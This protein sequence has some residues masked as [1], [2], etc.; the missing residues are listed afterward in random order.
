M[1]KQLTKIKKDTKF[2]K[3]YSAL[4]TIVLILLL[5][6]VMSNDLNHLGDVIRVQ[7]IIVEDENGK[8]RV[9]IGSP[10]PFASNRVRTDTTRV[11]ELWGGR[12]PPE[13]MTWYNKYNHDNYGILIL[14]SNGFD[15]IAIGSPVPDPNIGKRVGPSTG[16]TINDNK[17]FERSGYGILEVDG[18]NRIVLGL[19]T[20]T[21]TE[22]LSLAIFEDGTSGIIINSN[23]RSIFLGKADSTNW[24]TKDQVPFNGLLIN[25]KKGEEIILNSS[26]KIEYTSNK[27]KRH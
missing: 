12:F 11:K 14:D 7:G 27:N 8:E 19:D 21:G 23:G 4:I 6:K 2:L 13:Y 20:D 26:S 5:V 3:I 10:V 9:L 24:Y 15:R 18:K 16:I 25:D 22:G 17:G 1:D